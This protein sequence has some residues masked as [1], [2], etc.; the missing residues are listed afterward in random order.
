[1]YRPTIRWLLYRMRCSH[2]HQM[3]SVIPIFVSIR[4]IWSLLFQRVYSSFKLFYNFISFGHF[5]AQV[6][7]ETIIF[8]KWMC[9]MCASFICFFL[10]LVRFVTHT[11]LLTHLP[12]VNDAIGVIAI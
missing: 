1:M 9:Y 12:L 6:R 10:P 5:V 11:H 8:V 4:Y 3:R 2:Q 7:H